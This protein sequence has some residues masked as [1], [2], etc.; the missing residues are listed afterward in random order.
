RVIEDSAS[1]PRLSWL[2][3]G[4]GWTLCLAWAGAVAAFPAEKGVPSG[5]LPVAAGLILGVWSLHSGALQRGVRGGGGLSTWPDLLMLMLAAGVL[6]AAAVAY[7]PLEP[8]VDDEQFHR[9]AVAMLAGEGYGMPGR[10]AFFPPGMSLVLAAWYFV[11]A[12]SPLT[13]K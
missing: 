5:Y 4:F 7:F 13:G 10:L 9:Y 3:S 2:L 8:R 12:A 11:T 6:R 1:E